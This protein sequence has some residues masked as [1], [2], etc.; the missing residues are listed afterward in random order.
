MQ[1]KGV[2]GGRVEDAPGDCGLEEG[3]RTAVQVNGAGCGR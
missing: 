1:V 2:R 3:R